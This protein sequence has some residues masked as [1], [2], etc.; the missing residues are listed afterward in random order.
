MPFYFLSAPQ[1]KGIEQ[2]WENSVFSKN[3]LQQTKDI[4]NAK[5]SLKNYINSEF[6]V[7]ITAFN[8]NYDVFNIFFFPIEKLTAPTDVIKYHEPSGFSVNIN[9]AGKGARPFTLTKINQ[10]ILELKMFKES[11]PRID[12]DALEIIHKNFIINS[13][14]N[15]IFKHKANKIGILGTSNA[16][17][18]CV[19][20]LIDEINILIEKNILDSELK[21]NPKKVQN[22]KI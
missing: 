4:N 12:F 2:F 22:T 9:S 1:I 19:E 16:N 21:T 20:K 15:I 17:T 13:L 11:T 10:K 6:L 8:A 14:Q 7:G 5:L 3:S 18:E